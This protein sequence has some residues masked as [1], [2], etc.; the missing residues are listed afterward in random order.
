[1]NKIDDKGVKIFDRVIW[2][3]LVAN[4]L[5]RTKF[6]QIGCWKSELSLINEIESVCKILGIE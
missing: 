3:N 6:L 5:H 2:A 1:M 4:N